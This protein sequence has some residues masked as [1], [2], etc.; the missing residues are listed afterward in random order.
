MSIFQTLQTLVRSMTLNKAD[1]QPVA[2]GISKREKGKGTSGGNKQK[3]VDRQ[4][5]DGTDKRGERKRASE[6]S[7]QKEADSFQKTP[8]AVL[9]R[10]AAQKVHLKR[11]YWVEYWDELAEKWICM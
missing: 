2:S 3:K 11:D 8:T 4:V 7:Q 6:D 1:E 9:G 10:K 5:G